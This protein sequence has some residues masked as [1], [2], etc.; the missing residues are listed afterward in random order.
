MFQPYGGGRHLCVGD[1]ACILQPGA[2]DVF[3]QM[4][5]NPR[6][7][8]AA[9]PDQMHVAFLHFGAADAHVAHQFFERHDPAHGIAQGRAVHGDV[10][11]HAPGVGQDEIGRVETKQRIARVLAEIIEQAFMGFARQAQAVVAQLLRLQ[12]GCRQRR[13]DGH[14][15]LLGMAHV[16]EQRRN[17]GEA[18]RLHDPNSLIKACVSE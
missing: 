12:S 6:T 15:Q 7:L 18:E 2:E 4:P 8:V 16:F 14:A 13:L 1:P 9:S 11:E 10:T 3:H 5:T 17:R